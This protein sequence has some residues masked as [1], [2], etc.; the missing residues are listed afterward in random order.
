MP[1]NIQI[2]ITSKIVIIFIVFIILFQL[3]L[4][5]IFDIVKVDSREVAVVTFQ[6]KFDRTLSA[7][8]HPKVPYLSTNSATYD[9]STQS[10]SVQSTAGSK[11]QQVVNTKINLQYQVQANNIEKIYLKIGGSGNGG[12]RK[13]ERIINV[14]QPIFQEAVK[15]ST[16]QYSAADLLTKREE[17]KAAMIENIKERLT[18]Y[19][20]DVLTVNVEN[21]DFSDQF[22]QAIE[23]KVVAQQKAQQSQFELEQEKANL[24]KEKIKAQSIIV[25]GEALKANP[26]VLE[27]QKI[28]KWDGRLP[29]VSGQNGVI[30]DLKQP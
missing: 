22:D 19:Y 5:A 13:D 6:G 10:L 30:I 3:L 11:D 26:Q 12:N 27:E 1:N 9:I 15:T 2:K 16:A 4:S 25:R 23:N 14:I 18:P 20:I 29:Q 17:L 7:G 8:W 24:E 21:I 28:Q